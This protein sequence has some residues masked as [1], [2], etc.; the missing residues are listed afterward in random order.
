M[1]VIASYLKLPSIV[2]YLAAGAS[3]TALGFLGG[4]DGNLQ[5]LSALGTTLLLFLVG[6]E[7]SPTEI[8]KLGVP[9][10]LA[11]LLQV[12]L[13]GLLGFVLS[14][15]LGYETTEAILL[16]CALTFSSTI[17]V[18]KLLTDKKQLNSL[19]GRLSIGIFLVQDFFAL[20]LLIFL[21]KTGAE[22]N[23]IT[24]FAI[25]IAKTIAAL[26]AVY[27]LSNFV[28]KYVQKHIGESEEILLMFALA[29]GIGI[30]AAASLPPLSLSLEV[31]GFLAGLSLSKSALHLRI[32]QR[33][34]PLRDFFVFLFFI[35]LGSSINLQFSK[36][37]LL[38][39]LA[40]STFVLLIK[41]LLTT[42]IL[43]ILKFKPRTSFFAG[44]TVGQ[45]SEFSLLLATLAVS[46]QLI[47]PETLQIITLT[48]II[49]ITISSYLIT[50]NNTIYH[51]LRP[52]IA[53]LVPKGNSKNLQV[54]TF[55]DHFV[56][57]GGNRL[58]KTIIKT[59]NEL[60]LPL[61]VIDH[62]PEITHKLE[63][64]GVTA[65]CADILDH[66][67]IELGNI[68]KA[69]YIISTLPNIGDTI[70][71]V[72]TV[73]KINQKCKI[74][75]SSTSDEETKKLQDLKIHYIVEPYKI[76]SNHI[77]DILKNPRRESLLK[78][79]KHSTV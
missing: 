11:G 34:R 9:S 46:K 14:I 67:T 25:T 76:G 36:H 43:G 29:W 63:Q 13:T 68:A 28:L 72:N 48:G 27:L 51:L 5:E 33:V 22:L 35:T 79:F 56:V 71:L 8:K 78:N 1:T 16:A 12:S 26:L 44:L 4:P 32:S 23:L 59:L 10:L 3:L 17:I 15:A 30:A 57:I 50:T 55:K 69:K 64:E 21:S 40:F 2:A 42:Y 49:T 65:L 52:L 73:T 19:Y 58:G 31:G 39:A 41:P 62:D 38:I 24:L 7:L 66:H 70:E 47:N 6:L 60:N 75:V 37:A 53:L 45:V 74:I 54:V 18:V 20:L 61:L 77:A